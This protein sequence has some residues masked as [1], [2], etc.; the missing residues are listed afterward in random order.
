MIRRFQPSRLAL[1]SLTA[2]NLVACGEVAEAE[3]GTYTAALR[4]EGHPSLGQTV[5]APPWVQVT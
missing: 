2:G 4:T 5:A 1:V 3:G